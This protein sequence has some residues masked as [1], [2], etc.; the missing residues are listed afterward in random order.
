MCVAISVTDL[1]PGGF[2]FMPNAAGRLNRPSAA[3]TA[4]GFTYGYQFASPPGIVIV[5]MP[6]A[7]TLWI[8]RLP[9]AN[10]DPATWVLTGGQTVFLR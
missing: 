10:V 3:V 6:D 2:G 1:G 4:A 7:N 5:R 9:A 8:E